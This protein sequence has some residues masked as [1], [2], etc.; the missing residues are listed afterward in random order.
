MDSD[1]QCKCI[2]TLWGQVIDVIIFMQSSVH[3][4][5]TTSSTKE[6]FLSIFSRNS[7]TDVSEFLENIEK[8]FPGN[9]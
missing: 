5:H 9:W 1:E 6:V 7:E 8:R 3:D 4:H 2:L